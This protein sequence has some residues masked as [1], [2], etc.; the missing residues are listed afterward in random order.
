MR[1]KRCLVTLQS[2]TTAYVTHQSL[3]EELRESSHV[4][5][6]R[7]GAGDGG[8]RQEG[9]GVPDLHGGDDAPRQDLAVQGSLLDN[10]LPNV[11]GCY[12]TH[13]E[14]LFIAG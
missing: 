1:C 12:L 14:M 6:F 11:L 9:V 13:Y 5:F 2:C 8:L 7:G 10:P 3:F 4:A